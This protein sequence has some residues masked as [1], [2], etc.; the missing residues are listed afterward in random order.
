MATRRARGRNRM[1]RTWGMDALMARLQVQSSALGADDCW[2]LDSHRYRL[3]GREVQEG[4]RCKHGFPYLVPL[5]RCAS[6]CA[7]SAQCAAGA[8]SHAKL[9]SIPE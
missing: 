4:V 5:C 7:R 1:P 8:T 9:G 2:F 6:A 3:Q